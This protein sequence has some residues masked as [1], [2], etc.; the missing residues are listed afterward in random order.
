MDM[1]EKTG[2]K[3]PTGDNDITGIIWIMLYKNFTVVMIFSIIKFPGILDVSDFQ[4][5]NRVY[6]SSHCFSRKTFFLFG[7]DGKDL[8]DKITAIKACIDSSRFMNDST[9]RSQMFCILFIH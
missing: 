7:F 1:S 5:E 3:D 6:D 4:G 2:D 8:E 9:V